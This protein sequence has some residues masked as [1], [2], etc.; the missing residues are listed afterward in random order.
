V[1]AVLGLADGPHLLQVRAL[2]N[3]L[4]V[5]A[6]PASAS[7]ELDTSPPVPRVTAPAGG[8][9]VRGSVTILGTAADLDD[10]RFESYSVGARRRDAPNAEPIV[11]QGATSTAVVDAVIATWDTRR[12]EDD[13]YV[14]EVVVQDLLGVRGVQQIEVLVDNFAPFA[15]V[16]SPVVVHGATGGT[17]YSV[18]GDAALAIPPFAFSGDRTITVTAES[19]IPNGFRLGPADL[20][21][22]KSATLRL[23]RPL[24]AAD[25][26][27]LSIHRQDGQWTALGGTRE[28]RGGRV[29]YSIATDRMGV[30]AL[31]AASTPA[32]A[33]NVLSALEAEPRHFQPQSGSV[34]RV[35]VSFVL[36]RSAVVNAM[37]Y[38]RAGRPRR[39]IAEG[40]R[41]GPGQQV[42]YWDGRDHNGEQVT[43]A[44]YIISVEADGERLNQ[45]VTVG[46]H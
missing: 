42:L 34:D 35:S 41:L 10:H 16:T 29:F 15:D 20:V 8:A 32:G 22:E 6:T 1:P 27:A 24:D 46:A 37:V 21:L 40:L 4:L 25:D 11:I 36:G 23:A 9:A 33:P 31:T 19:G 28:E 38:N 39:V 17:V 30:Y 3:G 5:D 43:S 18:A 7:F 44:L 13:W 12:V 26:P 2:D 14:L 45:A